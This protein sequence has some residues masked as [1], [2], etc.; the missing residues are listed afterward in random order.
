L[1]G[2]AVLQHLAA[3][4]AAIADGSGLL[5]LTSRIEGDPL[6]GAWRS[7]CRGTPFALIDLG[8]LR[9]DEAMSLASSFIDATQ[10]VALAC[11]ERA[12]GNPLFLEQL[13]RNAEEGSGDT[14][15]ASIQSLVLARM[16]RLSQR[17]RQALQVAAVIGQRFDLDLL[18]RLIGAPDYSCDGLVANA[19]VLPVGEDFLIA[20][21]LIQ[22]GAYASLLRSRRRELHRQAADWFAKRDL[23]LHAQHLDRA[24]DERAPR[25]YLDAALAQ[26]TAYRADAALQLTDRDIEIA[27]NNGDRHA[28]I[29]LKGQLQ[30][31]VADITSSIATY[32][33]AIAASP[34]E[35]TLCRAQLGLAQGL[36]VS[37]G[38]GEALEL[39]GEAQRFAERHEMMPELARLHH[40]RGNILFLLGN[41]NGCRDEHERG[42]EYARRLGSPEAEARALGGLGD[43]AYAQGRMRTAYE[44]FSRCAALSR[45]HGYGR[46]EVANRSMVGFSR[47][48][49][50]EARQAREDGDAAARAARFVGQPRA[51]MMG[52]LLGAHACHEL[53]EYGATKDYLERVMRL[54]RQLGARRFEAQALEMEARILLHTGHPAE[55]AEILR[56][57]LAICKEAGRQFSGPRGHRRT[58]PRR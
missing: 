49:L 33:L 51:E 40:L 20:H 29:C 23:M 56:E 3:F 39:L 1:G 35:P 45:E 9:R 41:I 12:G 52:E 21:A 28:L 22:E 26:R 57:A 10:R 54:A 42:L 48:F 13:L 8:P 11:I 31:D 37:E 5:V 24:E 19:L 44:H 30:R 47:L 53:G 6:N 50:N 7:G 25:A 34:D 36:R 15:P 32:R 46:I 58:E 2:P 16:D 55:A 38:L 18:R 27:R 14:V 4:A 43:A 17:D